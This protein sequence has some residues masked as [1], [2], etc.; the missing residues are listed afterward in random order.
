MVTF[1]MATWA[2]AWAN[3][4]SAV[5]GQ[6]AYNFIEMLAATEFEGEEGRAVMTG[7][8]SESAVKA[9]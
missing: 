7:T 9:T 6:K 8:P 5:S 1:W 3:Q 2:S 4:T